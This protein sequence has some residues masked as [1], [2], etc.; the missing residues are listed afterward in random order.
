MSILNGIFCLL[1][2]ANKLSELRGF[3]SNLSIRVNILGALVV[4]T[5]NNADVVGGFASRG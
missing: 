1:N 5:V 4:F 2:F 3:H